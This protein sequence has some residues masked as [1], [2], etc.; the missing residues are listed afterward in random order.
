MKKINN[1]RM[2]MLYLKLN[3]LVV[4]KPKERVFR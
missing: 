4:N 3:C 2:D 1:D